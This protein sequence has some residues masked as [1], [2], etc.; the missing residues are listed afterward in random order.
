MPLPVVDDPDAMAIHDAPLDA[1]HA[2][3][4][5]VWT[6]TCPVPPSALTESDV[7][8]TAYVH[9][10]G[11][12]GA[13]APACWMATVWPATVSVPVRLDVD[14]FGAT[15]Y[16]TLP[17]PVPDAPDAIAIHDAPLDAVQAQVAVVCT[18]T[19]PFPPSGLMESDVGETS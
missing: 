8:D 7:G 15:A 14:V 11:G 2:Q 17:L 9:G 3:V 10:A 18:R 13:G 19:C 6:R 16:V 4:A 1:V 12:G 5:V